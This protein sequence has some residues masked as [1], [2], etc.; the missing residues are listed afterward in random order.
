[1]LAYDPGVGA[2]YDL[3][4]TLLSLGLAAAITGIGL[5]IALRNFARWAAILGGAVV[6]GGIAAMHY[7]GMMA[8]ELPG[9]ISWAP[10]LVVASVGLGMIFGAAS[11]FV[12]AKRDDL[13]GTLVAAGSLTLA[14]VSHHFTAMGAVVVMPDPTRLSDTGLTPSTLSLVV[15]RKNPD[16]IGFAVQPRR[17]V[18]ERFFAWIGRN[19]RLAKDFEATIDPARAFLYAASVMLLVRRIARAS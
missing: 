13:T 17:W 6:G 19:R 2:G 11:L 15:V 12:A 9:R 4:L 14:I 18:V 10:D 1:M 5:A 16:Q 3:G 7:T 8:L